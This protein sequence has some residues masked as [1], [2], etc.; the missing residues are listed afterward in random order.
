[1]L[2]ELQK[3]IDSAVRGKAFFKPTDIFN[4]GFLLKILF[5]F[6]IENPEVSY[7]SD[8]A[9]LVMSHSPET[10]FFCE[11]QLYT[12]FRYQLDSELYE[13]DTHA[14]GIIG[15]FTIQEGK[16][17]RIIANPDARQFVVIEAKLNARLSGRVK[18]APTY[19]QAARNIACIAEI[20]FD[21]SLKP[22]KLDRI[23]FYVL[24]PEQK[25]NKGIFN[26]PLSEESVDERVRERINQYKP[27]QKEE[28]NQWYNHWFRPTLEHITIEL[29]S[30]EEIIESIIRIFPDRTDLDVFYLHCLKYNDLNFGK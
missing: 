5:Q 7:N 22:T 21:A 14:D 4:E 12:H 6:A 3:L 29:I 16:K 17:T 19:D 23:G 13:K 20:L 18:N 8:K 10:K 26:V 28:L 1:M 9:D 15:H 2:P 25:I 24:A 11:G 30:W 27:E